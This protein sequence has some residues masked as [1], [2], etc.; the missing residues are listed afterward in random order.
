MNN[1]MTK[2]RRPTSC[3]RAFQPRDL[4]PLTS[5]STTENFVMVRDWIS[6]MVA[7]AKYVGK[8]VVGHDVLGHGQHDGNMTKHW[9]RPQSSRMKRNGALVNLID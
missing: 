3:P 9:A 4:A 6:V 7:G 2:K 8:N 5:C 1:R